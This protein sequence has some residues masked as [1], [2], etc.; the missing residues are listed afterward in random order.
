[1]QYTLRNIPRRLNDVLRRK[2][3]EQGKTLNEVAVVAMQR[4]VGLES[5]AVRHRDLGDL[6]GTWVDDPD[7]DAAIADQDRIDPD[8]WR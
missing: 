2:A 5:E 1:M 8:L 7:F 4:G 3:R 6:A